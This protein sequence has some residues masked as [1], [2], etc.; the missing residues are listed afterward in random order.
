VREQ[1]DTRGTTTYQI[2]SSAG[3]RAGVEEVRTG[4]PPNFEHNDWNYERG[5]QFARLAPISMP[6][7][8]GGRINKKALALLDAAFDRKLIL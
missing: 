8:V 6:L 4:R 3:F 1:A 7:R 5:R 2:L